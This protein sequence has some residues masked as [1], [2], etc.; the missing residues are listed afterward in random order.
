MDFAN[1]KN[2][3]IPCILL[4]KVLSQGEAILLVILV[5]P[6]YL[7]SLF[8]RCY[9]D[10][11]SSI[12]LSKTST[13][14]LVLFESNTTKMGENRTKQIRSMY[15][16]CIGISNTFPTL[17]PWSNFLPAKLTPIREHTSRCTVEFVLLLL[18]ILK[19]YLKPESDSTH[20]FHPFV[21]GL[22]K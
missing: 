22:I 7:S 15:G 11:K 20:H 1:G 13:Y 16:K 12:T 18:K 3:E 19:K 6:T 5:Q 4:I 8:Y 17:A 14:G 2:T 21:V 10:L 9:Q